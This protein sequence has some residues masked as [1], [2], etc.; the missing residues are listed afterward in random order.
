M[1][2]LCPSSNQKQC[3]IFLFPETSLAGILRPAELLNDISYFVYQSGITLPAAPLANL[4]SKL[5]ISRLPWT[6]GSIASD[7]ADICVAP[8]GNRSRLYSAVGYG[9]ILQ[10]RRSRS[11]ICVSS[12]AQQEITL[13]YCL[14]NVF[15]SGS[16]LVNTETAKGQL[17]QGALL[18]IAQP[19][20]LPKK[21]A[22][23]MK[24]CLP[25]WQTNAAVS[26]RTARRRLRTEQPPP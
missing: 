3:R 14:H 21:D 8:D 5:A 7:I 13:I 4:V 6:G 12:H 1:Q 9:R 23:H 2:T 25:Q 26:P 11:V 19:I 24:R 20:P 15:W 16:E 10:G 22:Q 18:S 17:S